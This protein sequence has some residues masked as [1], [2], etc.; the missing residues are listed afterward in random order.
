[1]LAY[2]KKRQMEDARAAAFVDAEHAAARLSSLVNGHKTTGMDSS[3]AG[4]T[5][6][7]TTILGIY[8]P[9]A[10]VHKGIYD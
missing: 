6:G 10:R 5:I 9:P 2:Y 7:V 8:G 4:V 3:A 1:M